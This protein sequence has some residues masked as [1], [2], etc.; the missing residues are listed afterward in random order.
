MKTSASAGQGSPSPE[1]GPYKIL[2]DFLDKY[3][4][5]EC[6]AELWKLLTAALS[7]EDADTWDRLDRGNTVFFCKHMDDVIKALFELKD[8]LRKNRTV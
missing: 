8:E 1:P 4:P 3:E 2:L 7:S 5:R 6:H